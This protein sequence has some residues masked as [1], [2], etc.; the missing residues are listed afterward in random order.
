MKIKLLEPPQLFH[1]C[2]PTLIYRPKVFNQL[3]YSNLSSIK[4]LHTKQCPRNLLIIFP[5]YIPFGLIN[6]YRNIHVNQ[7]L[8]MTVFQMMSIL[9]QCF[10]LPKT[11]R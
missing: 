8:R 4:F 11:G 10:Q 9:H 2:R 3:F 5:S 1:H 6:Q 7:L